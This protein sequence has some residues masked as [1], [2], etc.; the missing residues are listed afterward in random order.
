MLYNPDIQEV[1]RTINYKRSYDVVQQWDALS[2]EQR[3]G[4]T[5]PTGGMVPRVRR[6]TTA[7]HAQLRAANEEALAREGRL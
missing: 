2:S 7:M 1:L 6:N 3:K 4:Q 5:A